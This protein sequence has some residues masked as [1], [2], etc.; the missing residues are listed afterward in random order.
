MLNLF[1]KAMS[2]LQGRFDFNSPKG[3]PATP[4]VVR[5]PKRAAKRKRRR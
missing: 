3:S 5:P 2:R 1:R 4:P